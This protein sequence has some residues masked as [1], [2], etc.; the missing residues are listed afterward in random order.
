[1]RILITLL[2]ISI[3]SS[4]TIEKRLYRP[5]YH[6]ESRIFS[7][8]ASKSTEHEVDLKEAKE[9]PT[10]RQIQLDEIQ[11]ARLDESFT[12]ELDTIACDTLVLNDGKKIFGKVE[13]V[14]TSEIRYKKCL[15]LSGPVYIENTDNVDYIVYSNG[16][17]DQI[18][19][20]NKQAEDFNTT[21]ATPSATPSTKSAVN[22]KET[23]E[24]K[25]EGFGLLGF[26]FYIMGLLVVSNDL[27][28]GGAFGLIGLLFSI[29]SLLRFGGN[30]ERFKGLAFPILVVALFLISIVLANS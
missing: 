23:S 7:Q 2:V 6:I 3:L 19:L 15:N 21:V 14:S 17:R 10:S 13:L 5:G 9:E 1:M 16:T 30:R 22:T 18:K 24:A 28:L 12:N 20:S 4:C 29:I 25:L 27:E 26:L 8:S 11:E